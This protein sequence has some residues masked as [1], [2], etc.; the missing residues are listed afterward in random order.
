MPVLNSHIV[1][2]PNI[3]LVNDDSLTFTI[4]Y[5]HQDIVTNQGDNRKRKLRNKIHEYGPKRSPH[6]L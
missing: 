5:V 1:I 6:L 3:Y 4:K 2:R